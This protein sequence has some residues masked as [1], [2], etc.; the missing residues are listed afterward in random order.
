MLDAILR[1]K[2]IHIPC[3]CNF[4]CIESWSHKMYRGAVL[5]T[6]GSEYLVQLSREHRT[7]APRPIAPGRV[8]VE[9]GLMAES[10]SGPGGTVMVSQMLTY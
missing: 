9:Y 3:V 8:K 5:S 10:H 7:H 1:A 6:I 4:W 2:M